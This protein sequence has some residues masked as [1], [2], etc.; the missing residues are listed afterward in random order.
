MQQ[1]MAQSGEQAYQAMLSAEGWRARGI[2][3]EAQ[4]KA[5]EEEAQIL[6]QDCLANLRAALRDVADGR[7][8]P[9]HVLPADRE[10][11]NALAAAVANSATAMD[12]VSHGAMT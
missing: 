10:P 12:M 3:L 2:S 6:R 7:A 4:Q 1:L 8:V 9:A 11:L 5:R